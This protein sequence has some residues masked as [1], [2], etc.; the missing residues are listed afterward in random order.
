ML[1]ELLPYAVLLVVLVL[2]GLLF[3]HVAGHQ[4]RVAERRLRLEHGLMW[5]EDP[6]SRARVLDRDVV[7]KGGKIFKR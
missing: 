1:V 7:M 5:A 3:K 4:K 6:G 2:F